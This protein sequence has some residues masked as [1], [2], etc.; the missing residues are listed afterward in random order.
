[1]LLFSIT[2]RNLLRSR[3][4]LATATSLGG[5]KWGSKRVP[6]DGFHR[7]QTRLAAALGQKLM[8]SCLDENYSNCAIQFSEPSRSTE[9]TNTAMSLGH[10]QTCGVGEDLQKNAS[11][12]VSA[13]PSE[14][15]SVS[16]TLL[17]S[18][19]ALYTPPSDPTCLTT[20]LEAEN[21]YS[22][23]RFLPST[24]L[25][26]SLT[27]PQRIANAALLQRHADATPVR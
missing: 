12:E 19:R 14:R 1:M 9:H 16:K 8:R 20:P 24:T 7:S 6:E 26:P 13:R 5:E 2:P 10:T 11:S 17:S 3:S 18:D 21:T 25:L 15:P 27:L 22:R 23:I 4:L